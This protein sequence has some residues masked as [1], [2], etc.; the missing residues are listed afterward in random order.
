MYPLDRIPA[1]K[2]QETSAGVPPHAWFTNP[3][4]WGL[5]EQQQ[6]EVIQS[7][8]A[9]IAFLDA[10]VGR[11]LDALDRLELADRTIVVFVSDHGYHL[12][13]RG[14]WMEQTLFE[15]SARAPLIMAGAGVPAGGEASSRIV[16][17]VEIYPTVADLAGLKPPAGLQGRSLV[18]LLRNPGARWD[19]AAVT[20]V[21]RGPAPNFFMGYS[22]RTDR[23]RY[24]EWDGGARGMELYDEAND[25]GELENLADDPEHRDTVAALQR[26]LRQIVGK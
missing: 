14:Q 19:H 24:T 17:F 18:P 8:Y 2:P 7:Y 11:I 4:H 21:R 25:P 9:S 26:Q 1:P 12:G 6:R 23:W 15:R 5:G 22:I 16:E 13:D 3:P 10:N 20:Q